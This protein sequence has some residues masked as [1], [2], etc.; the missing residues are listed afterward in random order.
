MHKAVTDDSFIIPRRAFILG[1][2]FGKRMRPLTDHIPKPMI[3]I[4]GRSL[5]YRIL[6]KMVKAGIEEVVVNTHYK[7]D[8][9]REHLEAYKHGPQSLHI[10]I[11]HEEGILDTGG[12]IVRALSYFK[13][14]P[15]YV[16]AGDSLWED[17][18]SG[19]V[20]S[21]LARHWDPQCMDIVTLM[22]PLSRMHLTH[23]HGDYD[24]KEDGRVKRSLD[25][26]GAYMWT[27][28]RLNHPAIYDNYEET[29]F[30]FLDIMDQKEKE[31]RFF[32][33]VHDGDWHHVS[34]PEDR[35]NVEMEY[36]KAQHDAAF[37]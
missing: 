36:K 30:S 7:A 3:E 4:A 37:S 23:G 10:M 17:G 29:C 12:G 32:A 13:G 6:D 27:N 24:L 31:G 34:T 26:S 20:F 1:A 8:I 14:E 18:P 5:I 25:K 16:V 33:L 2:G 21:R 35:A 9:L 15:F 22:Q 19:C 28:I 11:S